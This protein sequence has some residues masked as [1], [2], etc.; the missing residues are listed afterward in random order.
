LAQS[1][2]W[3]GL[4]TAT[5]GTA[6]LCAVAVGWLYL[7]TGRDGHS[8]RVLGWAVEDHMRADL[9][10]AALS[11]AV[12]LRGELPGQVIFHADR[13]THYTSQRV[14]DARVTSECCDRWDAPVCWDNAAET[15]WSTLNWGP[16]KNAARHTVG[17]RARS[18]LGALA[19]TVAR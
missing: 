11:R 7:C 8:R 4:V 16:T 12:T 13:G 19:V 3:H 2:P 1:G 6:L 5:I 17:R 10:E 9:V 18:S 14:A 15:F